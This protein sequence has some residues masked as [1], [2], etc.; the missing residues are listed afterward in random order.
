MKIR[1]KDIKNEAIVMLEGKWKSVVLGLFVPFIISIFLTFVPYNDTSADSG[2][3][4][5][6]LL[7]SVVL[8]FF[9]SVV[10]YAFLIGVMNLILSRNIKENK[11][12]FFRIIVISLSSISRAFFPVFILKFLYQTA[13]IFLFLDNAIVFYDILFYSYVEL[14]VY[15]ILT[16]VIRMIINTAFLYFNIVYIFTPCVLA[17][18]PFI[19]PRFAMQMSRRMTS[20]NRWK[21]FLLIFSFIGWIILGFFAVFVGAF[22]AMAYQ[23]AAICVFYRKM[24][25]SDDETASKRKIHVML[26]TKS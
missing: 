15:L 22:F 2:V 17:Q 3:F 8:S 6:S 25:G 11:G 14:P 20:G 24:N 16:Q 7:E 5:F 23:L 18:V 1:L 4:L 21:L 12:G 10:S 19:K 13:D 26:R 9:S